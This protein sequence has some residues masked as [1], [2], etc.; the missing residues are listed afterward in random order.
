MKTKLIL[1]F[2]FFCAGHFFAQQTQVSIYQ[3]RFDNYLNFKG[4][5]SP[6]VKIDQSGV[7]IFKDALSKKNDSP[8]LLIYWEETAT[9][10]NLVKTAGMDTLEAVMCRKGKNKWKEA[11]LK[12]YGQNSKNIPSYTEQAPFT[13]KKIVIDPGHIAGNMD[14][15]RIEQ[16][17]LHFSK[18]NYPGLTADSIDI[19]E[20]I[21]TYQTASILKKLLEE[22]GAE[23]FLSRGNNESTF[24]MTYAD[25]LQKRKKNCI[26]QFKKHRRS[27][28]YKV[29]FFNE[30]QGSTIFLGLLQGL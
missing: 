17:F 18:K 29:F 9:F 15:A 6:F 12:R 30:R 10:I 16:K 5:L 25:W 27:K 11:E 28:C 20:G 13:G 4:A 24:G 3:Q 23:V 8:E 2:L 19:A 1:I 26:G 22:K 14:M 7:K 21:L